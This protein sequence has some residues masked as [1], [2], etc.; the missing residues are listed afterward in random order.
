[1]HSLGFL[2]YRC[3][4]PLQMNKEQVV[5]TNDRQQLGK[6]RILAE[7]GR[8]GFATV[9]KALD[10]NLNREVALKVLHPQLLTDPHF[11]Q[12]FRQ[13]ARTLAGLRHPHIVV[14]HDIGEAEARSFIAMEL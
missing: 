7:L 8:G 5:M 9:Y 12:Q 1:M 2:P 4:F 6:Y 10:T 11:V 13:E 3:T 14:I